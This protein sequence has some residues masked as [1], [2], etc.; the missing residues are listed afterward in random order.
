MH[1]L[2]YFL[3]SLAYSILYSSPPICHIYLLSAFL[4]S[5]LHLQLIVSELCNFLQS[6]VHGDTQLLCTRLVGILLID[7]P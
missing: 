1:K 5:S 7:I 3:P 2:S 4:N 6:S